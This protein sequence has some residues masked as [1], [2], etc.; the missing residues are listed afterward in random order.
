MNARERESV[1]SLAKMTLLISTLYTPLLKMPILLSTAILGYAATGATPKAVHMP[2]ERKTIAKLDLITYTLPI[3]YV[4]VRSTMVRTRIRLEKELLTDQTNPQGRILCAGSCRVGG[5]PRAGLPRGT[6]RGGHPVCFRAGRT[7][8]AA[9][10]DAGFPGGER[11]HCRGRDFTPSSETHPGRT[12]HRAALYQEG[13]PAHHN[14]TVYS[15]SPSELHGRSH[16]LC[17]QRT[18]TAG[19]PGLVLRTDAAG[20]VVGCPSQDDCVG[21]YWILGSDVFSVDTPEDHARGG[22]AAGRVRGRVG[23]L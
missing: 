17:G 4:I 20:L 5:H 11:I 23:G 13:A 21:Y 16:D 7:N 12:L 15:R 2:H 18:G 22:H 10:H 6:R 3:Q 19:K 9:L 1:G 8:F 14:G